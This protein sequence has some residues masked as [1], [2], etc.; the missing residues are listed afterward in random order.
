MI[1][2]KLIKTREDNRHEQSKRKSDFHQGERNKDPQKPHTLSGPKNSQSDKVNDCLQ[3]KQEV[4]F[5]YKKNKNPIH[6][7]TFQKKWTKKI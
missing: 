2:S 1:R 6:I 4:F 3:L 5:I 7:Q